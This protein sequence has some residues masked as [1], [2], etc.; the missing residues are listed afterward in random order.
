MISVRTHGRLQAVLVIVLFCLC[1]VAGVHAAG[2][3]SISLASTPMDIEW[4]LCLGGSIEDV[5]H[6]IQQTA[7]GGYIVA[8]HTHSNDGDVTLNPG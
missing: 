5:G 1:I 4:Q 6:S 8:G 2:G 3:S 7:D